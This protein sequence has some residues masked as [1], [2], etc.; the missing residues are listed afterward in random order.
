MGL[1]CLQF[2]GGSNKGSAGGVRLQLHFGADAPHGP[3]RHHQD[4]APEV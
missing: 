2:A 4:S 1:I 3:A